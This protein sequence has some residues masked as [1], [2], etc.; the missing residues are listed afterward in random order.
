MS[1]KVRGILKTKLRR[2]QGG[3][4]CYCG[5]PMTR[6]EKHPDEGPIPEDAETI[7]H[8]RRK[9]E[10]GTNRP[11]NIALAC[12]ACNRDRGEIDW[13]TWKTIRNGEIFS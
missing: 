12:F 4:C 10:G 3:A 13:L 7:E 9:A 6:W 5:R 2:A 8:L 1:P 11:D